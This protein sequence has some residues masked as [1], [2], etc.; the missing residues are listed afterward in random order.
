MEKTFL[1][2]GLIFPALNWF[3]SLACAIQFALAKK[4]SSPVLIPFVGPILIDAWIVSTGAPAWALAIPWVADI[5]TVRF[6]VFM[7]RL[8]R[9][10]WQTSRFTRTSLLSGARERQTA[11]I[12]FHRGGH[13][14][15]RKTWRRE[16]GELGIVSLGEPGMYGERDG[17]ITLLSHVGCTRR[18]RREGDSFVA[19]DPDSPPDYRIHG[20]VL[21]EGEIRGS[22]ISK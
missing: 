10:L 12:S 6:A 15:L 13:Y 22:E 3:T 8:L 2:A 4:T 20:W 17:V 9:E 14:V 18:I 11:E 5:G 7:P 19:E 21:R 1:V 16:P